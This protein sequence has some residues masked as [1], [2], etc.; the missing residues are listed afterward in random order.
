MLTPTQFSHIA[1]AAWFGPAV[2]TQTQASTCTLASGFVSESFSV[3]YVV[4]APGKAMYYSPVGCTC[5]FAAVLAAIDAAWVA[6]AISGR[7]VEQAQAV[8]AGARLVFEGAPTPPPAAPA[9]TCAA[10]GE[11]RDFFG[12]CGCA[13]VPMRVA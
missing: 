5:P 8:V 10:C 4:A 2:N 9:P 3:Y 7:Q 6:G 11:G 1:A 12:E 13:Y